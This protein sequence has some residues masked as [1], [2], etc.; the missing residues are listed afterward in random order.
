LAKANSAIA[1]PITPSTAPVM[2]ARCSDCLFAQQRQHHNDGAKRQRD[3][4]NAAN[5]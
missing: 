3:D 4:A 5:P 1:P 2:L